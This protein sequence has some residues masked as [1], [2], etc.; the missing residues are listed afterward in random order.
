[1]III[2]LI[3]GGYFVVLKVFLLK[4][5]MDFL[6]VTALSAF[7]FFGVFMFGMVFLE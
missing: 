1:M 7:A 2:M 6:F 3:C 5:M 4:I